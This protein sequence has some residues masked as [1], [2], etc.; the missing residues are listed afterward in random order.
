MYAAWEKDGMV[1]SKH[2]RSGRQLPATVDGRV[3]QQATDD[4]LDCQTGPTLPH[5]SGFLTRFG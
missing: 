4:W 2:E 5:S 1:A 3:V